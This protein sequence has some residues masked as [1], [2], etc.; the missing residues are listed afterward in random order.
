[1]PG[2]FQELIHSSE[3]PV[4]VDFY[5]DWCGPCK[6]VS[7]AV[8]QISSELKGR[9]VTV[10]VNVDKKEHVASRHKIQSIPTIMIFYQGRELMRLQGAYPYEQLKSQV[11]AHL[12]A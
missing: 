9:V 12:P 3:R 8:K 5:A 6:M 1:M 4:L 7:P 2:S 10:K 11:L